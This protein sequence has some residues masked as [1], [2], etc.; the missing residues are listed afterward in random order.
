MRRSLIP[1]LAAVLLTVAPLWAQSR[2]R[3]QNVPDIPYDT[4]ANPQVSARHPHG[5]RDVGGRELEGHILVDIRS[6]RT[7][8]FELTGAPGAD[9][10]GRFKCPFSVLRSG[11]RGGDTHGDPL[12]A[13][14]YRHGECVERRPKNGSDPS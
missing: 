3:A 2:A 7:R 1:G 8:S 10:A 4:V 5:R 14:S 6:Q 12:A 9:S 11:R 13:R